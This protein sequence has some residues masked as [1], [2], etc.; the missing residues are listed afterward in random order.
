LLSLA[1]QPVPDGHA[2]VLLQFDTATQL[3]LVSNAPN[4]TIIL[5]VPGSMLAPGVPSTFALNTNNVQ[6]ATASF[7]SV[8]LRITIY[9]NGP[10]RAALSQTASNFYVVD[11]YPAAQPVVH[12]AQQPQQFTN[13]TPQPAAPQQQSGGQIT[14]L[15]RLRY[16]DVSEV[17]GLL[18]ANV[19][20]TPSNAFNPQANQFGT[21]P[22]TGGGAYG[23]VGTFGQTGTLGTPVLNG[24]GT[25]TGQPEALSQRINDNIAIDRRLNA[26][27]MTGTPQQ[28]AQAE[29]IIK[30]IDVPVESVLIDTEVLEITDTGEKALGLP[31]G[32]STSTPITRIFNAQYQILNGLPAN[33]VPGSL[34][35]ATDIFYLVSNGQAK[36][37]A[38]PKILTE[39]R[40]PASIVTGDSLPIRI[41][42]PVG[43]GGVG[44]VTSQ[45][46]YV[47]VGVNLQILPRIT[48]EH[49]I[50][51]D[52][53]SQVSSVTGFNAAGDP[54][55]SS[56][57]AQT[58]VNL[59]EGQ[60]LVIGGL[61]Q[62][63]DIRNVQKLP[64]IGD[65]PLI[66]ALFRFYT[67][68]RQNTNLV[69]MITPHIVPVPA[70]GVPPAPGT[71]PSPLPQNKPPQ[72]VPGL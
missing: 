52:V 22:I 3:T 21:A 6:S 42:T 66:G 27:I 18:A 29:E 20:L 68:T 5:V 38:S 47:N 9:A 32:Q 61:L 57:Q 4:N 53:F 24:L 41:T 59:Y 60:T 71:T 40:L 56:R 33:A 46:E 14:H 43:V 44:A 11:V 16:A 64:L 15:Y 26:I 62:S 35:L 65:I 13:P 37:L 12:P 8:G 70:P 25:Q 49:D 36:V 10:S 2:R 58:R 55:I 30:L 63:R 69:I 50:E 39:D 51:T 31:Y 17:V 34:P 19:S 7:S 45:V 23:G 72:F 54:Q 1:A 67:E 48:G 28:I